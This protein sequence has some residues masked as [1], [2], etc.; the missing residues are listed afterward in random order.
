MRERDLLGLAQLEQHFGQI[1]TRQHGAQTEQDGDV[2]KAPAKH[3]E[4]RRDRHVHIGGGQALRAAGRTHAECRGHGVQHDV[5]VA[6]AHALRVAR[7]AGRVEGD[8]LGVLVEFGEA[9]F[10]HGAVDERFVF[11]RH[12][13]AGGRHLAVVRKHDDLANAWQLVA[14]LVDD[15]QEVG[16]HQQHIGVGIVERVENLRGRQTHVHG[17]QCRAHHRHAEI[18]FQITVAVPVHHRHSAAGAHAQAF[19]RIGQLRDAAV[20][21]AV[22]VAHLAAVGDLLIAM[23]AHRVEQQLLDEQRKGVGRWC[24]REQVVGG[25]HKVSPQSRDDVVE[26]SGR[27]ECCADGMEDFCSMRTQSASPCTITSCVRMRSW[28]D[29]V[30]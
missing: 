4:H 1:T 12:G 13:E 10:R 6:V 25:R 24:R 22:G 17:E 2:R 9:V 23:Q 19:K 3:V 16:V 8:G 26:E 18:A 27:A 20:E 21:V 15:G 30:H 28:G 7:G 29:A 11:A 5:A 14:D